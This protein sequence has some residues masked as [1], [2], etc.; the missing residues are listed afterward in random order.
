MKKKTILA[1]IAA[2]AVLGL[3]GCDTRSA[4]E[5]AADN[6]KIRDL[7]KTYSK[8][9]TKQAKAQYG[10]TAKVKDIKAENLKRMSW[11]GTSH[12]ITGKLIGAVSVGGKTFEARYDVETNEIYSTRNYELIKDS[13]IKYFGVSEY[14]IVSVSVKQPSAY[15]GGDTYLYLPDNVTAYEDILKNKIYVIVSIQVTNEL[16]NIYKS[17]FAE[18]ETYWEKYE[19]DEDCGSVSIAQVEE[20][21]HLN[22]KRLSFIRMSYDKNRRELK[23]SYEMMPEKEGGLVRVIRDY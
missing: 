8:A 5:K 13:V 12:K 14:N 16:D 17:D 18:L 20:T 23:F 21:K 3:S 9:F 6:K 1:I 11:T 22:N 2:V 4:A 15:P 7:E 19:N 10:T